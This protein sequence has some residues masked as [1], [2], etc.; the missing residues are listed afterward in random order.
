MGELEPALRE[1][2][3]GNPV[4]PAWRA[5]LAT[6]M[7]DTDRLE[8]AREEF[9][10]LA[11]QG[12]ADIPQDGDWTIAVTLLADIATELGDAQRARQLYKLLHPYGRGNVVIGLGAVCLGATARY[13]GRLATTMREEAEAVRLLEHALDRN[14]QLK[15]PIH[16]AHN[17]IDYARVL[18]PGRQA[19]RLIAA[20]EH[21]AH[22]LDLPLVAR[23]AQRLRAQQES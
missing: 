6:L 22:E 19:S 3:A 13:L 1:L 10:I 11:A 4:R 17:R 18:G 14:M 7:C 5:A 16:I 23:R 9:E 8:E 21:A 2:V 20:A 15:A 12:F